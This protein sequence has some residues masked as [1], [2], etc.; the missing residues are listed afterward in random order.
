MHR[1]CQIEATTALTQQRSPQFYRSSFASHRSSPPLT[2]F[3][4]SIHMHTLS[5]NRSIAPIDKQQRLQHAKRQFSTTMVFCSFS[6]FASFDLMNKMRDLRNVVQFCSFCNTIVLL[7]S[8]NTSRLSFLICIHICLHVQIDQPHS[9]KNNTFFSHIIDN[10]HSIIVSQSSPPS[11][12]CFA[13]RV[14]IFHDGDT[15]IF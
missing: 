2:R 8:I 14:V 12:Y 1:S 5:G 10:N 4:C 13:S 3:A 6:H 7:T 15:R 11:S 9:S